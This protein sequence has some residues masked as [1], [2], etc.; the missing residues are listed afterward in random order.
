M[1]AICDHDAQVNSDYETMMA[2]I[3]KGNPTQVEAQ[4]RV[5]R[6]KV[7]TRLARQPTTSR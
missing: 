4:L 3:Q 5:N 2:R 7:K 1:V 6:E